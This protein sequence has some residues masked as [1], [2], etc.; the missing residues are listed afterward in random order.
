MRNQ[1]YRITFHVGL[2]KTATTALQ[3]DFF[4]ACPG[5][6]A[7]TGSS[8][9]ARAFVG[10]LLAA[11]P[12]YFDPEASRAQLA[13]ILEPDGPNLVSFEGLSGP[14]FTGI[15]QLLDMRTPTVDKLAR[16]FPEAGI[17]LVLRRQD[18][19]ARSFYRQYV[20]SGGSLPIDRFIARRPEDVRTAIMHADRFRYS[21]YVEALERAF[22]GSVKV[23]V[24]EAMREDQAAFLREMAAHLGV[25]PPDTKLRRRNATR[26]G[27]RGMELTR[28]VNRISPFR[29]QLAPDRLLPGIPVPRRGGGW[30][31]ANPLA[32]LHDHWPWQGRRDPEREA[33]YYRVCAEILE[34]NRDDN[35]ALDERLDL[36]L[37]RFGYY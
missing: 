37:A 20:K 12:A 8:P 13:P 24:F 5:L 15:N 2:H 23:M 32:L 1:V 6:T 17:L 16:A 30:R 9:A 29:N 14:P 10:S 31:L 34:D 28:F 25:E 26:L 3:Q 7:L 11:D 22:P 18:T 19:L 4:P 21:P 33:R 27:V 35:R 36:G